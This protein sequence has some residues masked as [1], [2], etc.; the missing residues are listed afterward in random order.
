VDRAVEA[1]LLQVDVRDRAADPVLLVLLQHRRVRLPLA[2]DDVE[3]GVR[4]ARAGQCRTQRPL[5]DR[6]R[7]GRLPPVEHARNEPLLA[8]APRFG[9]PEDR[10]LLDHEL[11]A[12]SCH[13][14]GL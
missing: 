10:P 6:D 3:D 4:P 1:D 11:D 14:R 13:G 5:G 12:L 7:D 9:R 2:D 8:Q